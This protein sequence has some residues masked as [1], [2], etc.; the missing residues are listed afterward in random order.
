MTPCK[1]QIDATG[2]GVLVYSEDRNTVYAQSFD[3]EFVGIIS[4]ALAMGPLTKRYAM[5]EI[6]E[7]GEIAIGDEL[8]P[9]GW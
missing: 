5:A 8:P 3:P 4:D 7:S 9:Q 1:F 6:N 2:E